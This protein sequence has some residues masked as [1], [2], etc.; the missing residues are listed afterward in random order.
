MNSQK[1]SPLNIQ[2]DL[3]FIMDSSPAGIMIVNQLGKIKAANQS[4]HDC[5]NFADG[6]LIG[7]DIEQLI[8]TGKHAAHKKYVSDYLDKPIAKSMQNRNSVEGLTLDNKIVDLKIG[9]S[10]V[11]Y[12]DQA[13]TLVSLINV[14]DKKFIEKLQESNCVLEK[15]ANYDETTKLPNRHMFKKLVTKLLNI[16]NREKI[17]SLIAF[18]DLNHF[19][20][21]NDTYGH[22]AG[23]EVLIS[24]AEKLKLLP[25]E[26]D[27]CC[28][29]GG[30]EFLIYFHNIN[31]RENAVKLV[32][33]IEKSIASI[34]VK[35]INVNLALSASVGISIT[36]NNMS[37][38]EA[39][40]QADDSMYI[41]K[42]HNRRN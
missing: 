20:K 34:D 22:L 24:V 23:D 11:T 17:L 33:K 1:I 36:N 38:D 37:L 28:R 19:K 25:R 30:D 12:N 26:S 21:I 41:A 42:A 27:V 7:I 5:F 39:I 18:I 6:S 8:P 15:M 10:P 32:Q 9:L 16:S 4:A 14:T 35:N 3:S 40:Q 29:Y 13:C 2:G 31:H